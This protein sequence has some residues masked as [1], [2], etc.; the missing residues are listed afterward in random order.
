MNVLNG[1]EA[2]VSSE[3]L[4]LKSPPPALE[5]VLQPGSSLFAS[6]VRRALER[7]LKDEAGAPEDPLK[8]LDLCRSWCLEELDISNENRRD[9]KAIF[10][11]A[12]ILLRE[13]TERS[14]SY[15]PGLLQAMWRRPTLEYGFGQLPCMPETTQRRLQMA[16]PGAQSRCLIL[17]DDDL[18]GLCWSLMYE[19]P[20]DVFEIDQRLLSFYRDL[21]PKGLQFYERDL[22][23]GL[24]AEFHGKY[25]IIYTDPMYGKAGFDMFLTCCS[26]G[27]SDAPSARLFLNT[28]PDLIEDGESLPQRLQA[29]GLCL[30]RKH[31]SFSRYRLPDV[32][33]RLALESLNSVPLPRFFL[34]GLL[35]VPYYYSDLLEVARLK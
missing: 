3:E 21:S 28:R 7:L 29:V 20:C 25:D 11:T 17:G 22:T 34:R 9:L 2:V 30:A 10:R 13:D 27:L 8:Q 16:E 26:Q 14:F 5:T 35:K 1:L 32:T 24:P 33:R 31:P 19:Q 18:M 12:E 4:D 6:P 23:R 15:H